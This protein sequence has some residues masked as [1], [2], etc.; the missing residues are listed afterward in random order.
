MIVICIQ[1]LGESLRRGPLTSYKVRADK[2][3][4]LNFHVFILLCDAHLFPR[5]NTSVRSKFASFFEV[6][7]PACAQ[8][9]C[10]GAGS[11]DFFEEPEIEK[12]CG[13]C[14]M[15][16]YLYPIKNCEA[17]WPTV[18]VTVFE[19][20]IKGNHSVRIIKSY[21]AMVSINV[22]KLL[23]MKFVFS[24]RAVMPSDFHSPPAGFTKDVYPG[25]QS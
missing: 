12:M 11:V 6:I 25:A 10:G 21:Q 4:T 16:R 8:G 17:Q 2:H 19:R 15:T 9:I 24:C 20:K 18:R 14:E 7:S 1:C 23:Q 13:I 5:N 3:F 22:S